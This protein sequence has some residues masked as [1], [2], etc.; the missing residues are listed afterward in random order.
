[1]VNG[2][3][4]DGSG[5][6]FIALPKQTLRMG[7][8]LV[9]NVQLFAFAHARKGIFTSEFDGLL[10]MGLFRKVFIDHADRFLVVE[11]W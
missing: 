4:T 2:T 8:A 7:G 6:A 5:S 1:M 3:G 11:P 10:S 9:S